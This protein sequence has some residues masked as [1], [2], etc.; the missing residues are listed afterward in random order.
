MSRHIETMITESPD[1]FVGRLD[2]GGIRLGM[3]GVGAIDYQPWH[4]MY[5]K[6]LLAALNE[7]FHQLEEIFR[8]SSK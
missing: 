4:E 7:D 5:Q 1:C 3:K 6:V 8:E 2:D